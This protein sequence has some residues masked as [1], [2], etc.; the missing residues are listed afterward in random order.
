[1]N[2]GKMQKI[3]RRGKRSYESGLVRDEVK[4][5]LPTFLRKPFGKLRTFQKVWVCY[6]LNNALLKKLKY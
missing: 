1:M 5:K 3:L 6:F 4:N 2:W